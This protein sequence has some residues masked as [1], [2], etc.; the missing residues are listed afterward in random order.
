MSSWKKAAKAGQRIHKERH[1]PESRASLGLLEKKKDYKLRA[2]DTNK[3]NR[4][5]KLLRKKAL[6]KNPDE[7]YFHMINSVTDDGVHHEIEKDDEHTPEQLQLMQTQDLR[8]VTMKRTMEAKKIDTLKSQL[9]L[10]D[11]A[12]QTRNTHLFFVDSKKEAQNL[13][14]AERLDTHPALLGNRINRLRMKDLETKTIDTL[15]KKSM[16]TMVKQ[17]KKMYAELAKR[18]ERERELS[19]VQHKLEM[20]RHLTAPGAATPRKVKNAT[21]KSGPIYKWKFERKR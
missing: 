18:I 11:A 1:Q 13:D 10:L 9:H 4:T 20:K 17:K 16:K 19:V 8:Y 14:V 21:K 5:I 7:F 15:D 3:K 12:N 2:D 6:N